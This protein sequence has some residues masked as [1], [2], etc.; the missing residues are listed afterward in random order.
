MIVETMYE[1]GKDL[2]VIYR[3]TSD[4]GMAKNYFEK[5]NIKREF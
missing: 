2:K 4:G 1:T 5:A 3:E